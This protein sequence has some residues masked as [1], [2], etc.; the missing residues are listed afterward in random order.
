MTVVVEAP[1][2]SRRRFVR[3][4]VIAF[5]VLASPFVVEAALNVADPLP[6]GFLQRH[7]PAVRYVDRNGELLWVRPSARGYRFD[8]TPDDVAGSLLDALRIAEDSRFASHGGVDFGAVARAVLQA[9]ANGRVVSGASTL[10]MQ[11]ARLLEPHSRSL[12]GKLHEMRRARQLEARFDKATLLGAYLSHA[13]LGGRLYGFEAAALAWFGKHARDLSLAESAMLVAMLPAPSR[14]SPLSPAGM[15]RAHRDR[16]LLDM[17]AAG[18]IDDAALA[19]AVEEPL[20]TAATPWPAFAQ[21]ACLAFD[22][23]SDGAFGGDAHCDG[24]VETTIDGALQRRVDDVVRRERMTA[25]DGI[26]VVVLERGGAA[27]PDG[28]L[29]ALVGATAEERLPGD[30]TRAQR[31]AGS[32]WKPF[33]F[34]LAIE[35]GAVAIDG[36][37]DDRRI[38]FADWRPAN[39]DPGHAGAMRAADAL[40]ESRNLP[41]VRLLAAVTTQRFRTLLE[42]LGLPLPARAL[43]LDAA[44]GTL[45]VAPRDLARAYAR[46]VD[47][48]EAVGLSRASVDAVLEAIRQDGVAIKTGTSSGRRDA[49]AVGVTPTHVVVVWHGQRDGR[50]DPNL[51]GRHA[52][53]PL[54]RA[55]V[56]VVAK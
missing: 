33:L 28:V 16:L 44:L 30:D 53:V 55:V 43:H 3:R 56:D 19:A 37:V 11:L 49:W 51:V 12:W 26:A 42:R 9:I 38:E 52:S 29:R 50:G 35:L 1:K 34:A 47:A 20:P 25:I 48:P 15:L 4:A 32:T 22:G 24:I 10:T 6:C 18:V 46:F 45:A 8:V 7:P 5:A 31:S 14:R 54:L 41:A 17:H 39:F 27:A 13:P 23:S 40:F 21:H 36:L 2:R